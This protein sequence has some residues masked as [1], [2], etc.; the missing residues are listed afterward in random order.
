MP[1]KNFL[2]T[3]HSLSIIIIFVTILILCNSS[4]YDRTCHNDE[5]IESFKM[6]TFACGYHLT[7]SL[8]WFLDVV[9][10]TIRNR[11]TTFNCDRMFVVFTG[12]LWILDTI[13]LIFI[14][15][16]YYNII[17]SSTLFVA[18]IALTI[19]QCGLTLFVI[20]SACISGYIKSREYSRIEDSSIQET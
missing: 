1:I 15:Q 12:L 8:I 7:L 11:E 14:F 20:C 4:L 17:C 2:I 6:L 10:S 19:Y 9:Y 3:V 18:M 13:F 5:T 16:Y